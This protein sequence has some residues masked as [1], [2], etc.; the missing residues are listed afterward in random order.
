[1]D[2]APDMMGQAPGQN[3][4]SQ[5]KMRER[6]MPIISELESTANERV[7]KKRHI[8]QRWIEDLE[9]YH[10]KYD[11]ETLK[12]LNDRPE[13]SKA[14]INLT[15]SKTDA[16]SARLLDLLFPTDDRNWGIGPTP[17]PSLTMQAEDAAKQARKLIEQ[18]KQATEQEDPNA[19]AMQQQA[20]AADEHAKLL[21]DQIEEAAKRARLMEREIEDQLKHA[22][23]QAEMRDVVEDAVKLGTGISKGPLIGDKVR[24]R[25]IKDPQTGAYTMQQ[26][27]AILP[28]M[29]R[30]DPWN[31]FP[32]MDARTIGE[33]SGVFERHLLNAKGLRG[34]QFLPGFQKDAI[35][36]L[37]KHKASTTAPSYLAELRDITN[38]S[39]AIANDLYT[40]W[41]YY[42]PLT[43]EQMMTL[44]LSTGDDETALEVAEADPLIELQACVW[45][46][47]TEIL[48]F[49]I[50]PLDSGEPMYSVF[51][52]VKDEAS[53]F[54]YGIPWIMRSPQKVMNAAWRAMMDNAGASAGPQIIT[55]PEQFEP[56]DGFWGIVPWK[57]WNRKGGTPKTAVM[58]FINIP[59]Q[60][61]ELAAIIAMTRQHID[62]ET[63]IPQIAQGEQGAHVTK[64]AH[65]MSILMN[66]ASVV[67]RRVVKNFDDDLTTPNLRR[68]YD[69]NMQHNDKDE[70]KGD[71]EVDARGS[72][73]LLTREMQAQSLMIIAMQMGAHPVYGPMLKNRN[74]LRKIF[75]AHMIPA[76]E[77]MLTDEEID[78]VLAAAAKA[79]EEQA[80]AGGEDPA[81][82]M[83]ELEL[84]QQDMEARI[85]IANMESQTRLK[86]A[87]MNYDAQMFALAEKLNVDIDK[88]RAML[89]EKQSDRDSKERI[90]AT[91]AAMAERTGQHGG[92]YI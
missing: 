3:D 76:D 58:E 52:L 9:Q 8:E 31:F 46:C 45:F 49:A 61:A 86:I 84:K 82:K 65:G 14:Y 28:G 15:R 34:L 19:P 7:G 62:E 63:A 72:S 44:A 6:L 74:L 87:S 29:R 59:T 53:M 69:W 51:N 23:Y 42:G 13:R 80:G 66:S 43:A 60:Q 39:D 38:S 40:C 64:T 17:V 85:E 81:I 89:A 73:V 11:A 75:Q 22:G 21:H 33:S 78:A 4:E 36:R 12:K 88:L 55:D 37:L 2:A 50:Y 1:M 91:E 71:Y 70:I 79:Q 24:K 83:R 25:W 20:N 48:K 26:A 68:L 67:F 47:E 30:V 41:E 92:G 18:A 27:G 56:Q 16:M 32:D 10:G 54:G 90:V 77:V 35:R 57:F 5:R